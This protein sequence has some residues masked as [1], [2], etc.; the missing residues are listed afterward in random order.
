MRLQQWRSLDVWV[1]P[2][3]MSSGCVVDLLIT[4]G[5][6][7]TRRDINPQDASPALSSLMA[8]GVFT[9]VGS[10]PAALLAALLVGVSSSGQSTLTL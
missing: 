9:F 8:V 7:P 10:Q 6:L 5:A 4:S 2:V 3:H 1:Q